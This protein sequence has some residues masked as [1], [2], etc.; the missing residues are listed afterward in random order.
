MKPYPSLRSIALS[1]IGGYALYFAAGNWGVKVAVVRGKSME[2]TYY[3]GNKVFINC[4]SKLF[5][6]PMKGDIIVCRDPEDDGLVI[7]RIILTP[8]ELDNVSFVPHHGSPKILGKDEYIILGDNRKP[9]ASVDSR[10]YGPIKKKDIVGI[11][12]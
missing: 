1:L 3:D 2:P 8:G 11:V 10:D 12:E 4:Y 9:G 5:R 7:K 6:D